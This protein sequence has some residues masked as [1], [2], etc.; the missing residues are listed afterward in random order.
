MCWS[1]IAILYSGDDWIS[2]WDRWRIQSP[3]Q[4]RRFKVSK[5]VCV[6]GWGRQGISGRR[7]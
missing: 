6:V 7:G 2:T 5:G 4:H 1:T 3:W